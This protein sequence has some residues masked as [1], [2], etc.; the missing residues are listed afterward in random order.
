MRTTADGVARLTRLDA[1]IHA[2]GFH[3]EAKFST[4]EIR[5]H[6]LTQ[7][8]MFFLTVNE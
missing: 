3:R 5:L 2:I 8:K 1:R 6:F 7:R 4:D